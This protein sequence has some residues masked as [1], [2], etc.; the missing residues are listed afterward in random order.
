MRK[1]VERV[2]A[3]IA[4]RLSTLDSIECVM[5][6]EAAEEDVLDP[7]F[8]LTIDAYYRG[9]APGFEERAALL[10]NP[11][12]FESSLH[13]EKDRFFVESLPV[14]VEYRDLK[15]VEA[16]LSAETALE[17]VL[18]ETGTHEFYRLAEFRVLFDR[19]GWILGAKRAIENLPPELWQDL[20]A[21]AS[22]KMEHSLSDLGASLMM[23]DDY[24]SLIA[25]S[26]FASH[27][28]SLLFALNRRFEPSHRFMTRELTTLR[29]L[30]QDFAARWESLLRHEGEL[31]P[32]R[33]YEVAKLIAKSAFELRA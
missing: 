31:T 26:G 16:L 4:T 21:A 22:A 9:S 10:G 12:L 5:L 3:D 33:K 8:T 27:A 20:V 25:L 13:Q 7:Y 1:K 30:P 6:G 24:F 17:P 11:E 23:K 19:S 15:Q 32:A 29:A 18:R 14:H 28:A 2:S